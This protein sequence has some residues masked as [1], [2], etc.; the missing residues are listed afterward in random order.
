MVMII[1]TVIAVV[2]VAV[3]QSL[4]HTELLFTK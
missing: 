1:I 2:V 4:N 3:N